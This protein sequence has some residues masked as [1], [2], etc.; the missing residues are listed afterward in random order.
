MNDIQPEK[1]FETALSR[2]LG[3]TLMASLDGEAPVI[4]TESALTLAD[5]PTLPKSAKALEPHI[6]APKHLKVAL[7]LIGVVDN[8]AEGTTCAKQLKIGQSIVSLD[9]AYWRWDGL[10]VKAEASDRHALQL[11][12]MNRLTELQNAFPKIQKDA[13]KTRHAF[14]NAKESKENS[15]KSYDDHHA[16]LRDKEQSLATKQSE[17]NALIEARSGLYAEIAKF[18]EA[19]SHTNEE[20]TSLGSSLAENKE[21]LDSYNERMMSSQNEQVEKVREGLSNIRGSLQTAVRELDMIQQEQSRRKARLHAIADETVNLQ[22]RVIRSRERLKEL[23]ERQ[24]ILTDKQE[25]LD[26]QPKTMGEDRTELLERISTLEEQRNLDADKLATIELE[27][28]ETNR[29]LKEAE[30]ILGDAREMR[31]GTQAT[32]AAGQ[33]QLNEITVSIYEQFEMKPEALIAQTSLTLEADEAIPALEPFKA[34]KEKLIRSRDL[35]GAV[36]L[37]AEQEAQDLEKEVGGMLTERND[38]TQAIEELRAGIETLNKEARERLMIAFDHVNGHFQ[39]LFIQLY[40]GGQAH[41]ELIESD[42]PL[43]SG[44]EIFAQPPGKT[45]QSLS[46]LSGGEQTLASIALIF[47]MFLTNPS[48]ICVLDEIDAPP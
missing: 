32:A 4:W 39:R 15:S 1:G 21:T 47:A 31:A 27:L 33:E 13:E 40:G 3:D 41:L 45:L 34:E 44:L 16:H 37:R 25:S 12:Q 38:L 46:L 28:A 5:I 48:P 24:T 17:Q 19:L 36:N 35:I 23:Q 18:E 29:A 9:G 20:I 10:H 6:K 22:N 42:D 8:N 30:R 7:S 11:Q 26:N 43:N 2:A 14:E